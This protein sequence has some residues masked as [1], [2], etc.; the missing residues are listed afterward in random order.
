MTEKLFE[1]E[2]ADNV[3]S[4]IFPAVAVIFPVESTSKSGDDEPPN[5]IVPL[6]RSS[7]EPAEEAQLVDI[8]FP[9][10]IELPDIL[11]D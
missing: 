3:Q 5:L 7:S 10:D 4:A 9:V 8:I 1:M 6:L 2:V 11:V